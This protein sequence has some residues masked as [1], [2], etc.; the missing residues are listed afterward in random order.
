M[1]GADFSAQVIKAR[2]FDPDRRAPVGDAFDVYRLDGLQVPSLI[3][4]GAARLASS[5]QIVMTLAGFRG[6]VWIS[7][8]PRNR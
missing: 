7:R 3:T 1:W 6:D 2:R 4:S 8:S 5:N